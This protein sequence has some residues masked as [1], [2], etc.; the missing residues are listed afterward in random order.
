[1]S[2]QQVATAS[3]KPTDRQPIRL[4]TNLVLFPKGRSYF[5][6]GLFRSV[7][8]MMVVTMSVVVARGRRAEDIKQLA[9]AIYG[10]LKF[11]FH[12][13]DYLVHTNLTAEVREEERPFAAHLARVALHYLQRSTN[14]RCE[15][16]L[17]D[18]EQI[19]PLDPRS[20]FP[21]N[22]V[23]FRHINDINPDINQ[24]RAER[25]TQ[26]IASALHKNQLQTRYRLFEFRDSLQI[27]RCIFPYRRV[28]AR[29]GFNTADPFDGKSAL[30]H[31]ELRV[32][33]CVDVVGDDSDAVLGPEPPTQAINQCSLSRTHGAGNTNTKCAVALFL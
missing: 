33:F 24:L 9:A 25:R 29:P 1:M 6:S 5:E 27:H 16:N 30:S 19:G 18:D 10:T 17:V 15:I 23:P 11:L 26:V 12:P 21:R 2:C 28:R 22:L 7:S 8:V 20:A 13:C 3:G 32:F 4:Q 14:V 31:Q